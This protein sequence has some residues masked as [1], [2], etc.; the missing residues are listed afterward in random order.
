[1]ANYP[2]TDPAEIAKLPLDKW[3]QDSDGTICMR[4]ETGW[5]YVYPG[6]QTVLSGVEQPDGIAAPLVPERVPDSADLTCDRC[7]RRM[8]ASVKGDNGWEQYCERHYAEAYPQTTAEA[9]RDRVTELLRGFYDYCTEAGVL[10]HDECYQNAAAF[11]AEQE[12]NDG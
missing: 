8:A 11:F 12:K 7:S 9:Q 3:F 10:F 1:M 6:D 4:Q 5:L 2:I